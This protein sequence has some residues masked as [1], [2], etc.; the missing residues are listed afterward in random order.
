MSK[1]QQVIK[2]GVSIG[3][4]GAVAYLLDWQQSRIL[5]G[6]T[7]FSDLVLA[8]GLLLGAYLANG[9][10]L[11]QLQKRV[12]LEIPT[13]L[14]WGTY[15][16]GLLMNNVLPSGVGGDVVRVIL[17][18]RRGYPV[19]ALAASGLADRFLGL[20]GLL[21]I[22][23]VAMMIV[24]AGLP[25]TESYSR[26]TGIG[27]LLG[28]ALGVWWIP[29]IGIW[30]LSFA[31]VRISG[32]LRAKISKGSRVFQQIFDKPARMAG[33]GALSLLSHAL[34]ILSYAS[35]GQSLL[36]GLSLA[37]Y[38][39]AIPGVMLILVLP[40]S[41]GGLGVRELSTVG[42]LIWLGADQQAALTLSLLFL[43][44]TWVSVIPAIFTA[45]H[46]GFGKAEIKEYTD[47]P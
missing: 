2:I 28:A 7:P 40:I 47:A 14:F 12:S 18:T 1:A 44:I 46:Y 8:L 25:M 6:N 45:V 34:L 19:G 13:T 33:P 30:L 38:F 21:A 24:P 35:L 5:I 9:V 36:P 29:R 22:A 37:D 41:I 11:I 17:L 42:L 26:I 27:L 39:L 31:A 23:G 4:L 32:Q 3:L 43:A 15:Y 10:R 16:T 20:F